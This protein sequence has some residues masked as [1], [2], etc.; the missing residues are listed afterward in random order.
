M[1]LS[2]CS[3]FDSPP[4]SHAIFDSLH[5]L[6]SSKRNTTDEQ[7]RKKRV[8]AAKITIFP[9]F[10]GF[11]FDAQPFGLDKARLLQPFFHGYKDSEAVR[12][13]FSIAPDGYPARGVVSVES[14]ETL[15]KR[16]LAKE[17]IILRDKMPAAWDS[18][19]QLRKADPSCFDRLWCPPLAVN[20]SG[21]WPVGTLKVNGSLET[22]VY[23]DPGTDGFNPM[24]SANDE[25]FEPR[26][27]RVGVKVNRGL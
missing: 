18:V 19:P 3:T 2:S 15:G 5:H 22:Y 25:Q 14:I 11:S 16:L 7:K 23:E 24:L 1:T 9:R 27:R 13:I 6:S 12:Q 20:F 8:P 10:F 4:R 17:Q 26:K 21:P